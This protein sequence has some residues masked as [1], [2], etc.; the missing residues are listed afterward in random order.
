MWVIFFGYFFFGAKFI[1]SVQKYLL[2]FGGASFFCLTD[3]YLLRNGETPDFERARGGRKKK[4]NFFIS[5]GVIVLLEAMPSAAAS[6]RTRRRLS[7]LLLAAAAFALV[8]LLEMGSSNSSRGPVVVGKKGEKV[9]LWL[10][11]YDLNTNI[12]FDSCL[13]PGN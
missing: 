2:S 1:A 4:I 12:V 9:C 13:I 3:R 6:D 5:F 10:R 11:N 8:L 7:L